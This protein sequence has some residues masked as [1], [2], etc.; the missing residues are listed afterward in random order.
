MKVYSA[1][2]VDCGEVETLSIHK[3][4][5]GAKRV[6]KNHMAR[7]RYENTKFRKKFPDLSIYTE[8]CFKNRVQWFVRKED[9]KK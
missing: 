8:E 1:I 4:R 2:C 6:I 7:K 5:E 3:T 9:V